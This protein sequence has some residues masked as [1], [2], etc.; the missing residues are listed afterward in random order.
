LF[1]QLP[2]HITEW[3]SA[4][5]HLL[6]IKP[7]HEKWNI[8]GLH[9]LYIHETVNLVF[10]TDEFHQARLITVLPNC[11]RL[12]RRT[13]EGIWIPCDWQCMNIFCVP[14]SDVAVDVAA[15]AVAE[16]TASLLISL[17]SFPSAS[18]FFCTCIISA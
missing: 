2:C 13:Q 9:E 18:P 17:A 11:T 14:H 6:Y 16:S 7:N 5:D 3:H 1:H 10:F 15:D 12:G 8:T 4:V